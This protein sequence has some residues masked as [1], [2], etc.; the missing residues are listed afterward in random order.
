MMDEATPLMKL[1]MMSKCQHLQ[2]PEH[3]A[4][5]R[6][7]KVREGER[8]SAAVSA[9]ASKVEGLLSPVYIIHGLRAPKRAALSFHLMVSLVDEREVEATTTAV[10][11]AFTQGGTRRDC[12]S[13]AVG[14]KQRYL[15]SQTNHRKNILSEDTTMWR[16]LLAQSQSRSP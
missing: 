11:A 8:H 3:S 15:A 9:L 13:C 4:S 12:C 2:Q 10:S 5:V 14:F 7:H 1:M 6:K 16:Y